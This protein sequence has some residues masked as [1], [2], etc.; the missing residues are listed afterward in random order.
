MV[1]Y[2]A[3]IGVYLAFQ[4]AGRS[5][6]MSDGEAIVVDDQIA[7]RDPVTVGPSMSVSSRDARVDGRGDRAAFVPAMAFSIFALAVGLLAVVQPPPAGE[8][9]IVFP[10][11]TDEVSA[12]SVVRAAGGFVVTPTRFGNVVV[13]YSPGPD[14]Q[15][16]VREMGAIFV[17]AASGLCRSA[18]EI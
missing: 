11:L 2:E 5:S 3:H 18:N 14:F 16:R 7:V 17:F 13:A 8:I 1:G 4:C 15:R 12:W 10:P 9:A 6:G